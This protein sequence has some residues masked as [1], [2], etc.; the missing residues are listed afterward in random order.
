MESLQVELV[1]C[2]DR[3]ETHVLAVDSLRDGLGIEEVVLVR[4]H[5]WLY[6]LSRDQ[7]HIMALFSSCAAKKVCSRT[8]LQAHQRGLEVRCETNQLL[9]GELFLSS[10]LPLSPS[11]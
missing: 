4:I 7:L 6:E 9:L 8:C 11:A 10:T 5:E 2:L 1:I 3:N